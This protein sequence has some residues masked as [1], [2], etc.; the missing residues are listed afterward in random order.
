MGR[1]TRVNVSLHMETFG[2]DKCLG[3]GSDFNLQSLFLGVVDDCFNSFGRIVLNPIGTALTT[4]C[5]RHFTNHNDAKGKVR[6]EGRSPRLLG[7]SA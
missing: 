2:G 3:K 4:D 6:S 1:V 5:S 7:S